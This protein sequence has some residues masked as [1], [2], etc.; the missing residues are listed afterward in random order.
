MIVKRKSALFI[1]LIILLVG[2]SNK[3]EFDANQSYVHISLDDVNMSVENLA[4]KK[5]E[6]LWDEPL[7]YI[8]KKYHE[9]YGAVFS[10]Y[11]FE[12]TFQLIGD[13][14][15][16]E[17][18]D[19]ADWLKIGLHSRTSGERYD[20][21]IDYQTGKNDWNQFVDTVVQVTGTTETIDR[22]PRLHYYSGSKE[23]LQGMNEAES[24]AV[25][26]LAADDDRMSYYLS[27][28][29]NLTVQT[30]DS[31][32]D[33]ET[34]LVFL[35]TDMR[36]DW[37]DD[38]FESQNL[39]DVPKETD[40]YEE[41]ERRFSSEEYANQIGTYIWFCHEWRIYDGLTINE[42]IEWIEDVCKFAN[43]HKIP[44]DYPQNQLERYYK[45]N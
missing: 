45:S 29:E 11:V 7:F 10:L 32:Y 42:N 30:N 5:Y 6:S 40:V 25:G 39:Y 36:G 15:Q 1:L 21:T 2:C 4:D 28:D 41:L 12:E 3:K 8:L 18:S 9:T 17:F 34:G 43:E 35:K 14:Y 16:T 19:S 26:F 23:C 33:D 44:F 27:A 20:E 37:F 22:I 31:Y 13:E 38:D 24:G